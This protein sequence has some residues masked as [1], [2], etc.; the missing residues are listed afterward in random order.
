MNGIPILT[1]H[2]LH[3][4]D[5]SYA[6]NDHV[7]LASDLVTLHEMGFSFVPLSEI[8]ERSIRADSDWFGEG[9]KAGISF[10]D[11]CNQDFIDFDYQ[12]LPFQKS[13]FSTLR[14]FND[15][16]R[17]AQPACATSF[18]IASPV[19]TAILDQTCIAG[20][21]QWHNGWWK[22]AAESG[23]ME[24]GNHS[25]DHLHSTLP[26]VCHSRD[27]RNDFSQVDNPI[28]ALMQVQQAEDYIRQTIGETLA[29]GLFAYPEG[30]SHTY[31]LTEFFPRQQT[32]RAAFTSDGQHVTTQ[33]NRWLI[34][35]YV[36]GEH[37]NSTDA[38]VQLVQKVS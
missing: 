15:R 38:L 27:A 30:K 19:A 16:H 17:P 6:N 25:W 26:Y 33:T 18:V 31:L 24:I 36:C 20:R 1:Y 11:G 13:F 8:A 22:A 29:T 2:S 23:L 21:D 12:G 10:D 7:A 37:W 35:R 9:K 34:P 4:R 28:D 3:A 14:D 32:I 5:E